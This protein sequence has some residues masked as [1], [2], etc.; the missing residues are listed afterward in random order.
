M[1]DIQRWTP[2]WD[3]VDVFCYADGKGEYVLHSDYVKDLEKAEKRGIAKGEYGMRMVG[4]DS[5]DLGYRSGYDAGHRAGLQAID[6]LH[7]KL[8]Y[9]ENLFNYV[10]SQEK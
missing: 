8:R 10:K 1:S 3:G 2:M 5:F 9:F 4:P 6:D 7:Q